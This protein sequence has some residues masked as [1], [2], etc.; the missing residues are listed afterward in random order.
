M[1]SKVCSKCK[2]IKSHDD[3]YQKP[4]RKNG[5]SECKKCFNAYCT[6]RWINT[7][8]RAIEYK[9]SSC[10]NCGK[11]YPVL[12]YPVFDFHHIVPSE[13]DVDWSKLRRRS[14]SRIVKELD[15]CKLLCSNCHRM[16]HHNEFLSSN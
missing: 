5:A 14:W 11:S 9:G 6:R 16:H 15:K 1:I 4:D 10:E 12:P 13:K 7:K 3:F 8:I 2:E